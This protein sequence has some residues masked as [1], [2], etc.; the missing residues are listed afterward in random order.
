M[1]TPVKTTSVCSVQTDRLLQKSI[2][3]V[4]RQFRECHSVKS[5][6][7]WNVP[8]PTSSRSR[9]RPSIRTSRSVT[10]TTSVSSVPNR[11]SHQLAPTLP[12]ERRV[13]ATTANVWNVPTPVFRIATSVVR[14]LPTVRRPTAKTTSVCNVPTMDRPAFTTSSTVTI[15]S[16]RPPIRSSGTVQSTLVWSVPTSRRNRPQ[17]VRVVSRF[18]QTTS[19]INV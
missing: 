16:H 15:D 5:T 8:R 19:V 13:T 7:V 10:S 12:T 14:S 1:A 6:D 11:A 4:S 17:P 2:Q 9:V 3:F 18:V